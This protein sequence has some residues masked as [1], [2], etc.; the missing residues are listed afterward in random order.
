MTDSDI[1]KLRADRIKAIRTALNL[2]RQKFADKVGI[3]KST[4][5]NWEEGRHSG[6]SDKGAKHLASALVKAGIGISVE[7]LSDGTGLPP[8]MPESPLEKISHSILPLSISD[9]IQSDSGI[10][11]E[12]LFFHHLN[13]GGI[14]LLV[15]DNTM[16]PF[17]SAGDIVAGVRHFGADLMQ[18][19]NHDCIVQTEKGEVLLRFVA[20]QS[21][22]CFDLYQYNNALEKT[23]THKAVSL[24]SAAPV[25]WIR[26]K[27]PK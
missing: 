9:T 7:W 19:V 14:D 15:P 10:Q 21:D 20:V 12:L 27:T 2:S 4:L 5:Q 8:K 3:K 23:L 18:T 24:F 13:K 6:L 22:G 17:Y 16:L 11:Q 1:P 26:K 25:L